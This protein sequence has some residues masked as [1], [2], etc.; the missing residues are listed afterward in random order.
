[1]F[2]PHPFPVF[3]GTKRIVVFSNVTKGFSVAD[4]GLREGDMCIHI[5]TAVHAAEAMKTAGTTHVLVVR[6][7]KESDKEGWR[8]YA[9]DKI[10]GYDH[11]FF[12]PV[13]RSCHE[14]PWWP[15]YVAHNP[16]KVPTTGFL[17]YMM[18]RTEAPHLPIVLAGFDPGHDHGTA[19]YDGHGWKYEAEY[20]RRNRVP[21]VKPS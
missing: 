9:P 13:Y 3:P 6:H 8:W 5:N 17:A 20:Y 18:A 1:M 2:Y 16:G 14:L 15:D 7:G 4:A 11:V 19:M 21:L 12:T 10:A